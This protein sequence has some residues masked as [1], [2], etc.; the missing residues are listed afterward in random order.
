MVIVVPLSFE[1]KRLPM[2]PRCCG[3]FPARRCRAAPDWMNR[4]RQSALMPP[5]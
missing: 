4:V 1:R 3:I 5:A 2:S